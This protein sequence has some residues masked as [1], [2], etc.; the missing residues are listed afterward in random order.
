MYFHQNVHLIPINPDNLEVYRR[1]RNSDDIRVWC[2][3]NNLISQADQLDWYE[4]MRKD[5][6]IRMYEIFDGEPLGVCGLTSIDLI[7]SRAEFSL[8]IALE[9]QG[10]GNATKA[11]KALLEV[12]FHELNLNLIW[13]ETFDGNPALNIF[14]KLGM[15]VEGTRR[16]FYFKNGK[17]IDAHLVSITRDE[18][19]LQPYSQEC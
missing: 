13:G 1:W 19:K 4:K 15:T 14:K 2:R 10:S 12:G 9:W 6:T 7:N 5:P 17:Y 16:Q 3:Q 8:Y 11:L 18:W